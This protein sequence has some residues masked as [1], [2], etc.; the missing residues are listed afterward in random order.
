MCWLL[1]VEFKD[2][3]SRY[4]TG[5]GAKK[6]AAVLPLRPRPRARQSNQGEASRHA[7]KKAGW[8][9]EY[10]NSNER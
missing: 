3:L 5:H 10:C 1:D 8:N 7:A 9:P 6:M 4:R 2:D